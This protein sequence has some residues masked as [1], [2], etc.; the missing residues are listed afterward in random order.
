M[1]D[2][3]Q[4]TSEK[5]N[6]LRQ[7]EAQVQAQF[8]RG[9]ISQEQ[10]RGFRRELQQTEQQL[11][12]FQQALQDMQTEQE[13]VGQ[14]TRQMSALFEATGTSVEDYANVIGQR[15]VRAI[16]NGSA[17]SRDLEYAFQRIG[18]QAI[19]S[20]GDIEQLRAALA[21]VDSG[22][23]IQNIRRDLQQLQSEAEETAESVEGIGDSLESVAG[24]LVAGGGIAGAIDQALDTST[25]DTKI[26][27]SME[28]PESSIEAVKSSVREVTAA[29]GDE[30]AALEGVRRQ[31]ALNKD[32]SDETN[33]AIIAGATTIT[34]AYAGVDFTELIQETNEISAALKI[35][36]E[37]ALGLTNSL[38]KMGF[39]PEQLDI[40]AEYGTQLQRAGYTGAEV[41]ALFAA[42]VQTD[43]WNI[44]VLL[45]G[46][47]E[48]R[49]VLAEFG[50]GV[51]EST[52]ELLKGTGISTKQLQKWGK[53]VAAGGKGG[54]KAMVEVAKALEG[55]DDETSRNLVGVKLFGT[56]YEEHG[57]NLTQ[58]LIN[59]QG[60][61]VDLGSGVA[62]LAKSTEGVKSDPAVKFAQA[63]QDV[64]TAAEPALEVIAEIISKIA[65]WISENPKLAATIASI[66]T[67]LGILIGILF[68]LAPIFTAITGA[69]GALSMGILPII[70][71]VAGVAAGIAALIAI[72]VLL[73]KN[74]DEIKAKSIEIWG[75]MKE[76]F[77]QTW[78][79]IS[80]GATE[81]W[82]GLK[83]W[84]AETWE[85]IKETASIVWNAIKEFF[86]I[87]WDEILAAFT[88]P[89][90]ILVYLIANNWDVIKNKTAEI[91]NG[92]KTF[93]TDTWN[94]IKT[95]FTNIITGIVQFLVEKWNNIKTNTQNIFNAVKTIVTNIWTTITTWLSSKVE[96][97][98]NT[99]VSK[100]QALRSAI[101]EK[102][103]AVKLKA[104]EIWNGISTQISSTVER[105][106]N[107]VRSKFEAVRS[108]IQEKMRAAKDTVREIINNIKD[109]FNI[110]LY[111]SGRAIIQ[112]A[113]DGIMSMKR[114][115][116]SKVEGVVGAVRDFW[117]FSPA[118]RGPLS[119]IDKMDFAGPIGDSIDKSQRPIEKAMY[120]LVS[121]T[122]SMMEKMTNLDL[123]GNLNDAVKNV[124]R[125]LS[126]STAGMREI[127]SSQIK[128]S[129]SLIP[130]ETV[131]LT[132]EYEPKQPLIVQLMFPDG[133]M[134]A[135]TLVD[136]ITELQNFNERRH[137]TF[138]GGVRY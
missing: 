83:V 37:E 108:S 75:A 98:K 124:R 136:D 110:D 104:I 52:A 133:R 105:I 91:W 1:T 85:S 12:G 116:L 114:T 132:K 9:E 5:L 27:I 22:N 49:I 61:T 64:K 21:S 118:K 3:I 6:Q 46:L 101:Q 62:D 18:R 109:F 67:G 55:V 130:S 138:Q 123:F 135:Q 120:D 50:A 89:I 134:L 23:S 24:A 107:T 115:I 53:A 30:E 100:F 39:P 11:A 59:A 42:G 128:N 58:T 125:S 56:L 78:T 10:Y 57:S 41:Q 65:G 77:S 74:W 25:L 32:A 40:I 137:K 127:N 126:T 16:Q 29:I 13:Q 97:M 17:T 122:T 72:G 8:D 96:A 80:T 35:T 14:R 71:I 19:G 2:A 70:G 119:D 93:F 20:G 15:L 99:V 33:Q 102:L 68:T 38:L 79:D 48:G 129:S 66:V 44:D 90:G 117:P 88:G 111:H 54:S 81:M 31:W 34:K 69:A 73:Y 26:E 84:L 43:S 45:D 121:K 63:I 112:S 94:A 87:W 7:A 36:D 51:D 47:K 82:E 86:L 4:S 103:Y 106:K 92:I 95:T 60:A 76:W 28:I 113:I 131:S